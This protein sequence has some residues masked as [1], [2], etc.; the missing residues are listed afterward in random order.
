VHVLACACTT[1]RQSGAEGAVVRRFA[2]ASG[3]ARNYSD[4]RF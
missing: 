3:V 2:Q 1:L 4:A